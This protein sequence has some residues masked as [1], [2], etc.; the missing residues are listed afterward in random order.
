M[1]YVHGD[2][3]QLL[4]TKSMDLGGK[5]MTD[6]QQRLAEIKEYTDMCLH[7]G[8]RYHR[9]PHDILFLLEEIE[10]IRSQLAAE[11]SWKAI[12]EATG[13]ALQQAEQERDDAKEYFR[14]KQDQVW[15]LDKERTYLREANTAIREALV[16]AGSFLER[17]MSFYGQDLQVLGWHMNNQ[18]V[19]WDDFFD[20]NCAH[21]AVESV[22]SILSR[23]PKE[24]GESNGI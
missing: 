20:N 7:K 4:S 12:S 1:T 13:R 3:R 17:I 10:S 5:G 18:T 2:I 15:A 19:P 24:G 9:A 21:D 14:I 8:F 22:Q 23:Y 11:E 6:K 16:K